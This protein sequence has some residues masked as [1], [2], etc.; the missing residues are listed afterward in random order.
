MPK[1]RK[2]VKRKIILDSEIQAQL[3]DTVGMLAAVSKDK[4]GHIQAG[5]GKLDKNRD[6]VAESIC[7][8]CTAPAES[9]HFGA[10]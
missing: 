3:S 10:I 2:A 1:E 7:N 4:N 6:D 5:D 8:L 9:L